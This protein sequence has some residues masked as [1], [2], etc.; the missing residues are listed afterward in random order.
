MTFQ[1]TE[2][3]C[4]SQIRAT[5]CHTNYNTHIHLPESRI[6]FQRQSQPHSEFKNSLDYMQPCLKEKYPKPSLL[7]VFK[8]LMRPI[9]YWRPV[10]FPQ[11]S[12][13]SVQ[14]PLH[15]WNSL[16]RAP[17]LSRFDKHCSTFCSF[18]INLTSIYKW[19]P[20]VLSLCLIYSP[21][22]IVLTKRK[23]GGHFLHEVGNPVLV[24]E[25]GMRDLVVSY[26]PASSMKSGI[27]G[28][29][30]Q[31]FDFFPSASYFSLLRVSYGVFS[32]NQ[33]FILRKT[34]RLLSF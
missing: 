8:N 20:V 2:T 14:F 12:C 5:V 17:T 34:K 22:C 23:L 32:K 15:R 28:P 31:V 33:I 19:E 6:G 9:N 16:S 7:A 13:S 25:L 4:S 21:F 27:P 3:R 26:V 18:G 11:C 30:N 1:Y 10:L 29:Q 24:L